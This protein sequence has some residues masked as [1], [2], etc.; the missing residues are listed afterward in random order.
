MI[1]R[2]CL[3]LISILCFASC[4]QEY[5]IKGNSDVMTHDGKTFYL[6]EA[7]SQSSIAVIDS[8]R[9]EHGTFS[10]CGD[11]DT[12]QL[13]GLY[14][15]AERVMPVVLE[16]GNLTIEV[17]HMRTKLRGSKLNEKLNKL[18][19][20]RTRIL[21]KQD[22]LRRKCI[23]MLYNG[24]NEDEIY[25]K[26][27]VPSLKLVKKLEALETKF[28][29]ENY[30]NTLGPGFFIWLFGQYTVPVITPQIKSILDG[31][32]EEFKCHPYIREYIR[33]AK[34]TIDE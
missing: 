8:S 34:H 4:S 14:M 11:T 22:E 12:I 16:G 2:Q 13:V 23:V 19:S 31:A 5:M 10:F 6:R 32:P 18:L 30:D 26:I 28:I 21:A 25:Q 9:V 27:T 33:Q 7:Y 29:K 1:M 15:G 24:S 20:E 3:L 17:S